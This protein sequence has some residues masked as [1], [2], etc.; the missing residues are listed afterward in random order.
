MLIS[1]PELDLGAR[2]GSGNGLYRGSEVCLKAAWAAG[3]AS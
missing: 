3:S 2:M 1:G